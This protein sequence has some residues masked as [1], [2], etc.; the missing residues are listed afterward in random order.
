MQAV[1]R[2][3]EDIS[4]VGVDDR[5]LHLFENMFPL[6][7]GVSYNSYIIQDEKTALLDTADGGV[8]P[9]FLENVDYVLQGRPVDYMIVHH[10]EP[11]HCSGI[12]RILER[13]PECRM[14]AT[15]QAFRFFDQFNNTT[16]PE[17][18]KLMVKEGDELCLGAHKLRFILAPMVHWPEV[19]MSFDQKD[20]ILF[21][22]DAFG[23][24]GTL[25]GCLFDREIDLN[26]SWLTDARRY[27][28]NIVGKYGQQVQAVLKKAAGL[29]IRLIAPL[30]GPVW[31]EDIP[32]ILEKYDIWSSYRPE[33][34]GAVMIAYGSMYGNTKALCEALACRL[35]DKGLRNIKVYDVSETDKSYL[36][37]EAFRCG[38]LVFAAPTY[39]NG[40]YPKMKE[41]LEDMQSLNIQG[42]KCTVLG[43][44]TWAPQSEKLMRQM[45]SEMKEMEVSEK[46]VVVRS[47]LSD[48]QNEELEAVAEDILRR[49][50]A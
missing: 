31:S 42:R 39:N 7:H 9:Q 37:A 22:A 4:W 14:V 20:G 2:L 8:L 38:Y 27:Y 28:T 13:Y 35:G 24:F 34:P 6:P 12:A 46:T 25:D 33:D 1:R 18:R 32:M 5:R 36:I 48:A 30:H 17:E 40:L 3:N 41:L 11:D 15:Q 50:Q 26:A 43:N 23:T 10:M 16:L 21:S 47:R 29:P 44:G 49:L 45:L 19:M